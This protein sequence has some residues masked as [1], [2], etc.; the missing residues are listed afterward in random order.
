M[1]LK[2]VTTANDHKK[3]I[4]ENENVMICCGRMEPMCLPVYGILEDRE[5]SETLRKSAEMTSEIRIL[6]GSE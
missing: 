3:F 4:E 2:H 1:N 6:D 5:V